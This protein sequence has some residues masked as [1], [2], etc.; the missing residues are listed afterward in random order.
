MLI[1]HE[2]YG[3]NEIVQ[4]E[5]GERGEEMAQESHFCESIKGKDSS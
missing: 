2:T 1:Y 4:E 5:K 3:Y